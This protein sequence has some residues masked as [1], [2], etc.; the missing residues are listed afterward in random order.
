[1]HLIYHAMQATIAGLSARLSVGP[2]SRAGEEKGRWLHLSAPVLTW[3]QSRMWTIQV[4]SSRE[5]QL[6]GLREAACMFLFG[7]FSFVSFAFLGR[8]AQSVLDGRWRASDGCLGSGKQGYSKE[9]SFSCSVQP[10]ARWAHLGKREPPPTLPSVQR[11]KAFSS[12]PSSPSFLIKSI[13]P[14]R[15]STLGCKV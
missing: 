4:F 13:L 1:M 9:G 6:Q 8:R 2:L 11:S 10:A 5:T 14:S 15:F 3:A 7:Y 12:I